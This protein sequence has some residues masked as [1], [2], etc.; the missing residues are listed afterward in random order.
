M[1]PRPSEW[2]LAGYGLVIVA[3]GLF[4]VGRY[5]AAIW[6]VVAHLLLVGLL[7]LFQSS[8]LGPWGRIMRDAAPF[9]L[10]LALYG[11]LDLLSGFGAEPTH[12]GLIR[13][14]ERSLFGQEISREWWG[15]APSA[16]WSS[17]FHTAYFTYYFV[18]PVPILLAITPRSR[19]EMSMPVRHHIRSLTLLAIAGLASFTGLS[20][21]LSGSDQSRISRLQ[22]RG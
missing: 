18:V 1:R 6:A 11:A 8:R 7:A 22:R 20:H 21:T 9:V 16:F 3:T 4:R 2:L 12:D 15:Q 14:W 5:P 19:E 13:H 17:V 10:L